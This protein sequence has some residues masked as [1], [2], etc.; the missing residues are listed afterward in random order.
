MARSGR[1]H[2]EKKQLRDALAACAILEAFLA[3]PE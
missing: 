2:R 3:K 1:T